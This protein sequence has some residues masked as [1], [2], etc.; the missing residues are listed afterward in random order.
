MEGNLLSSK[1]N[2]RNAKSSTSYLMSSFKAKE[3]EKQIGL[4]GR[5][6]LL[7]WDPTTMKGWRRMKRLDYCV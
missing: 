5:W 6:S 2:I 7:F 4:A 3:K 1:S